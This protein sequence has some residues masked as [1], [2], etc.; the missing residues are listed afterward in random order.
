MSFDEFQFD[1]YSDIVKKYEA[2]DMAWFMASYAHTESANK[3]KPQD[4]ASLS[5]FEQQTTEPALEPQDLDNQISSDGH[6]INTTLP[7]DSG[8][9]MSTCDKGDCGAK[10]ERTDLMPTWSA[11]NSLLIQSMHG[12]QLEV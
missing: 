1:R 11:T 12:H 10:L 7:S 3:L 6:I 2:Y 8:D 4:S 5:E 9:T